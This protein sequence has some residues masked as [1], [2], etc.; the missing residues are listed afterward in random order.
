MCNQL[1]YVQN[2]LLYFLAVFLL[3]YALLFSLNLQT[4]QR[5][6]VHRK[7][8]YVFTE[9]KILRGGK[10]KDWEG[11]FQNR[12]ISWLTV[13]L[14]PNSPSVMIC[15]PGAEIFLFIV[16]RVIKSLVPLLVPSCFTQASTN[17]KRLLEKSSPATG[18]LDETCLKDCWCCIWW[19]RWVTAENT[20]SP[21]QRL[22]LL[23]EQHFWPPLN[24]TANH[25]Q[26]KLRLEIPSKGDGKEITA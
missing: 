4:A 9:D 13:I 8:W 15:L 2:T 25:Q 14:V 6:Q 1:I 11:C 20:L 17:M 3:C 19:S 10:K 5:P 18:R 12:I 24:Q 22:G 23:S 7:S 21:C 26:Q 16:S